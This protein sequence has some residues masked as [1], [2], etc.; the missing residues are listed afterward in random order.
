[1]LVK[2]KEGRKKMRKRERKEGGSV[3]IGV[4]LKNLFVSGCSGSLLQHTRGT[5]HCGA[6]ASHRGWFLLLESKGFRVHRLR[7]YGA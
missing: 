1:M 3:F 5:L 2:R 6:Q 4:V 7:S